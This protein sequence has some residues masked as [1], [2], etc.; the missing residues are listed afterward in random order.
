MI[1]P[2]LSNMRIEFR[3][4]VKKNK[5]DEKLYAE[6]EFSFMRAQQASTNDALLRKNKN[7]EYI[8]ELFSFNGEPLQHKKANFTFNLSKSK[9]DQTFQLQS[10]EKGQFYLGKLN[11]VK[12]F[13]CSL[14]HKRFN[15]DRDF[16]YL[17]N[18]VSISENEEIQIPLDPNQSIHSFQ[19]LSTEE[20]KKVQQPEI[21]DGY[22]NVKGLSKGK[23]QVVLLPNL[24]KINI[25]V[26]DGEVF[27]LN[28]KN[29]I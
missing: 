15:I 9:R 7:G 28:G 12:N 11:G 4:T 16:L 14:I 5:K 1:P 8:L 2:K 19:I 13:Q 22:L 3:S 10:D 27:E 18:Q 23:Y 21:K 26:V 24:N 6:S 20:N 25:D 29:V 17:P